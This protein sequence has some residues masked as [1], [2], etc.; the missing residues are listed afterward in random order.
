MYV[1]EAL[2]RSLWFSGP[3][4]PGSGGEFV[5]LKEISQPKSLSGAVRPLT[6]VTVWLLKLSLLDCGLRLKVASVVLSG[7]LLQFALWIPC[8][9]C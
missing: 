5:S 1:L 4:V 3:G 9:P 2:A 8:D 6:P 7:W